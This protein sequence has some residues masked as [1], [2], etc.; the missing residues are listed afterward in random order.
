MH[1]RLEMNEFLKIFS[2]PFCSSIFNFSDGKENH[3]RFLSESI[4][5]SIENYIARPIQKKKKKKKEKKKLKFSTLVVVDAGTK[6][7]PR[8]FETAFCRNVVSIL[9]CGCDPR[10]KTTPSLSPFFLNHGSLRDN[11]CLPWE[12]GG[13]R[14]SN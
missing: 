12:E 2:P 14:G 1:S 10:F 4:L 5:I 6:A 11:Y 3:P 13:S 8:F 9:F 7:R